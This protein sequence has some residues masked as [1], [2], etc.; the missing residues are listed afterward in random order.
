MLD[1]VLNVLSVIARP[2]RRSVASR[3]SGVPPPDLR[4]LRAEGMC[5]VALF[6]AGVKAPFPPRLSGIRLARVRLGRGEEDVTQDSDQSDDRRIF[7]STMIDGE[8]YFCRDHSMFERLAQGLKVPWPDEP[9]ADD[10]YTVK[11]EKFKP[12]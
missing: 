12:R 11:W 9:P 4:R 10:G 7:G 2:S 5:M 1:S 8:L 3:R 6:A